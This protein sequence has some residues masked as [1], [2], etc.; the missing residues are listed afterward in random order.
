M[1]SHSIRAAALATGFAAAISWG[2][3]SAHAASFDGPWSVLVVTRSGPCDQGYR[4]GVTIVRGV[5]SYAGGGPVSLTGRA[6]PCA[7]PAVRNTPLARGDCRA[8]PAAEAGAAKVR[9]GPAPACGA[10]REVEAR[11]NHSIDALESRAALRI[12][13]T[14]GRRRVFAKSTVPNVER[15][16]TRR[17][18]AIGETFAHAARGL[19]VCCG[20]SLHAAL[21]MPAALVDV[22]AGTDPRRGKEKGR[23]KRCAAQTRREG[24]GRAPRFHRAGRRRRG[25]SRDSGRAHLG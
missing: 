10:R 3:L 7:C 12:R 11:A 21:G 9:A 2:G 17:V 1:I 24:S 8:A 20:T 18:R 23:E 16:N 15:T 6:S 5:V 25:H 19:R 13:N 14:R 4:Y 22:G